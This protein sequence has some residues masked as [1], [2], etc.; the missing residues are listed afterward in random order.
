MF[1]HESEQSFDYVSFSINLAFDS[2][3]IQFMIYKCKM[4]TDLHQKFDHLLIVTKLCLHTSFM[5]LTT[6]RL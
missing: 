5:Q 2:E 1:N 4:R 3:K 6:C